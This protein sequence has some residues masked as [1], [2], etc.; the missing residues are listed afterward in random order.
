MGKKCLL[1]K[2][3][4]FKT[5]MSDFGLITFPTNSMETKIMK[6]HPGEIVFS[7]SGEPVTSTY[8]ELCPFLGDVFGHIPG[9]LTVHCVDLKTNEPI[10]VQQM[11]P[12][13]EFLAKTNV[14]IVGA[15]RLTQFTSQA[16]SYY[17]DNLTFHNCVHLSYL[18]VDPKYRGM[19]I[20][21]KLVANA[22]ADATKTYVVE[23]TGEF[24]AKAMLRNGFKT[25]KV[26]SYK[27]TLDRPIIGHSCYRIMIKERKR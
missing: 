8:P 23:C 4:T 1:R 7:W 17:R 14:H 16:I 9:S 10:G 12:L 6:G 15:E 24:S 22:T 21:T 18:A 20:S 26:I 2:S 5:C 3:Q 19:G 13:N 11:E 27:E 25:V